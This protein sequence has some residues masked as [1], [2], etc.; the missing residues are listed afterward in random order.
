M[1]VERGERVNK[2][3][4]RGALLFFNFFIFSFEEFFDFRFDKGIRFGADQ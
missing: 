3:A 1:V 2:L 4:V